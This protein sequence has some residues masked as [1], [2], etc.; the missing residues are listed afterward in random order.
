MKK[1]N[2]SAG[3]AI[4]PA[5]VMQGASQACID[6]NGSGL[7]ILEISHRSSH[8]IAV[9]DEAE[10]LVREL[11]GISDEYAVLFLGGGASTQFM[12]APLNLLNDNESAAY[13]D[14]GA[15]ANKAIKEAKA[16]GNIQVVASSKADNYTFIPKGYDIPAD[17]KYLHITTNNTIYGT[18]YQA[19]PE[20]NVPLIADMSSDFLSRP[21]DV[22]RFD[23]IYAGAQKNLGPAGVTLVIVKKSALGR[24]TNRHIPTM[25]NYQTHIENG[26]M[27]NTPPV[28]PIFVSMLTLRWIKANGGL[29]GMQKRNEEKAAVLYNEIEANPFFKP[30]TAT[31]DRSRMNV[32]FVMEN[33]EHEAAFMAMAKEGNCVDIKG[34]RSVGGFRASIYNAMEKS[35]VEH[36]VSIMQ[37]FARKNG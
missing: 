14:T 2:F 4:L 26:S 34:H 30:V 15:W 11:M 28:F 9:T 27:F 3:P 29:L 7:S 18:Q 35:S 5:S 16:Y 19:L 17:S 23:L 12:M 6:F 36:L 1:H 10:Q 31:E 21:V 32:T 20:T 25:L 33:P 13:T 22:N 37:E 24:V 8:F